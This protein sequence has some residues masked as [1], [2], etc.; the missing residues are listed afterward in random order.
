MLIELIVLIAVNVNFFQ[1][2]FQTFKINNISWVHFSILFLFVLFCSIPLWLELFF[3]QPTLT[4]LQT[5]QWVGGNAWTALTNVTVT[6]SGG[7]FSVLL[8]H[9]LSAASG[10]VDC[11]LFYEACSS[12]IS[13]PGYHRTSFGVLSLYSLPPKQS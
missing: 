4:C 1:F 12:L 13:G 11:S 5:P 9:G 8:L 10:I 7:H 3:S 6:E 2:S